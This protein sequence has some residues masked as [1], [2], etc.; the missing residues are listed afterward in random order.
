MSLVA[1]IPVSGTRPE[2]ELIASIVR[3]TGAEPGV[4]VADLPGTPDAVIASGRLACFAMGCFWHNHA[5]CGAARIPQ[6]PFDWEGKLRRNRARDVLVR[7]ELI[8]RGYRV[9]WL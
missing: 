4:Q 7:A 1:C 9:L 8:A 2:R 6:T 5:G 3:V